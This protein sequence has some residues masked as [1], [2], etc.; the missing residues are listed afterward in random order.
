MFIPKAQEVVQIMPSK[1]VH[2][3]ATPLPIG[4]CNA[5]KASRSGHAGLIPR[6]KL[7]CRK[8]YCR[9]P[10]SSSLSSL[11]RSAVFCKANTF[12]TGSGLTML[13]NVCASEEAN[14]LSVSYLETLR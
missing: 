14:F 2:L 13:T 9:R 12:V 4:G 5:E 8:Y 10:F 6:E 11:A 1:F 7:I 3:L